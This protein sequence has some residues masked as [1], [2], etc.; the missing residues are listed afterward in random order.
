MK[1]LYMNND[2]AGFADWIDVDESTNVGTLFLQKCAQSAVGDYLVK[3][4]SQ[5]APLTQVL[6]E[7]DKVS[8]TPKKVEG[9][10]S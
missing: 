5:I 6:H 7:G 10:R 2:G 9:A 3:V 8:F 4:N 1:I